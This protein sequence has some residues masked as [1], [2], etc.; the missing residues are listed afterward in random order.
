MKIAVVAANGKA[1]Q[2]ITKEAVESALDVTAIV[3]GENKTVANQVIQK[4]L[5]DLTKD[6]IAP[7]DVI[8]DAFGQMNKDRL[9]EHSQ[10]LEV[11][12]NLVSESNKRLIII[13]GAGSLYVDNTH[14]E[15][16]I[17]SPDMPEA[18]KPI[19]MAQVK[20]FEEIKV[21]DEVQWTF[22]CPAPDFQFEGEKTGTYKVSEDEIIGSHVSYA[23]F[24]KAIIDEAMESKHI[25]K[26]FAVFAK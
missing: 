1:G 23:D 10:S 8:I 2:L 11:L 25:Q 19:S 15:R 20:T 21:R 5:F 17:D 26:R 18:I 9:D 14:T 4:D 13:G 6:D 16:L 24:A 12:C 3:R 7:F 22:V